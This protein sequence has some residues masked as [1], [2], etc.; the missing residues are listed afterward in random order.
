MCFY[1]YKKLALFIFHH[2]IF[3]LELREPEHLALLLVY[4]LTFSTAY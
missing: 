4:V 1:F 3:I 2:C